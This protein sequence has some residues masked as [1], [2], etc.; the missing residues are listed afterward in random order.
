M[1]KSLFK[2]ILPFLPLLGFYIVLVLV[3]STDD[4]VGDEFRHVYYADN[5]VHGFY[6][7]ADNPE[8]INGPGYPLVLAPFLGMNAG[9][10]C[11][12]LLNALFVF[13]ALVYFKKTLAFFI[14]ERYAIIC[15]VL[16]GLYPPLLRYI[17]TIYSEPLS[18][19][20]ACALIFYVFKLSKSDKLDW[21]LVAIASFYAGFLVL[22][23][24]IFLQVLGVSIILVGA[25]FL[26]K[27]NRKILKLGFVIVGGFLLTVPYLIYA[28]SLTGKPFYLGTAGGEILYHRSTPY[29]NEWGNWFSR[30][31]ILKADDADY[32]PDSV[33]KDL[34]QLAENH[35]D[36]YLKLEPLN[37]LERDSVLKEVAIEN[38]KAHP[39]KYLK[40]TVSNLGRF[41]FHY[42][43]S[44]R[45]QNLSAFGYMIP[46]MFI[47]VLWIISLL[48]FYRTRKSVPVEV[49]AIMLFFLAYA[50]AIV[51]L[52]GRGR[53]FIIMVPSMVLFFMYIYSKTIKIKPLQEDE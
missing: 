48:L 50:S 25:S 53:N 47:V 15:T 34:H 17:P 42:P 29:E 27:R 10:L 24:I 12:R 5:I 31:N 41:V 2:T 38:M 23:K 52:D 13:V 19:M 35:R 20:I 30:D 40:N 11:L 21:K 8:L 44:Y 49:K 16:V 45:D 51:L 6:T 32:K 4:L 46:N 3:F 26:W 7:N 18:V 1:K 22:V 33:Y 43:F 28:Y 36:V 14:K 9:Y 37:Y 39:V